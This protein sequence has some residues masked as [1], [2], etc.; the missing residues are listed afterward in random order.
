[1]EN[2]LKK[3]FISKSLENSKK[4]LESIISTDINKDNIGKKIFDNLT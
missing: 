4:S 3:S 1:M 2:T